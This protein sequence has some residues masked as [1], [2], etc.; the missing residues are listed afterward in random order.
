MIFAI[1]TSRFIQEHFSLSPFH[2]CRGNA[3]IDWARDDPADGGNATLTNANC[4]EIQQKKKMGEGR[5]YMYTATMELEDVSL[6][7]ET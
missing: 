6:F 7:S 3:G 5:I 2:T 1:H 4:H